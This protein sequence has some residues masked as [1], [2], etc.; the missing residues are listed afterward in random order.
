MPSLSAKILLP[1]IGGLL[2]VIAL[3]GWRGA[4]Q[5]RN[6]VR[7]DLAAQVAE[8]GRLKKDLAL[9]ETAA[10]ERQIDAAVAKTQSRELEDARTETAD[11]PAT[12]RLRS[13]CVKLRQ[14]D[15]ARFDAAP[16]C[17]RFVGPAGTPDSR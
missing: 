5:E 7:K 12:R 6:A 15:P 16:A 11:D 10:L 8:N 9:K 1:L 14:Q 17:R 2:L 3:L 13:L 4:I